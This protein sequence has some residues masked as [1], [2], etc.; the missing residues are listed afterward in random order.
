MR[1]LITAAGRHGTTLSIAQAIGESAVHALALLGE[2]TDATVLPVGEACR[3]DGYD[4]VVI[5]SAVYNGRWL[6]PA[7]SLVERERAALA[8]R[9]VWLFS[10]G[11]P[12]S[13]GRCWIEPAEP[14]GLRNAT[15]AYEH[16]AFAGRLDWYRL[17]AR[18]RAQA[19]ELKLNLGEHR[20]W[21]EIR[22]WAY[23]IVSTLHAAETAIPPAA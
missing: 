6:E 23:T 1:V 4:A 7:W 17:D 9:P 16:R 15:G 13:R 18:E 10:S 8:R 19:S 22:N 2:R 5:G 12:G 11:L 14:A 21:P 3:L 20:N